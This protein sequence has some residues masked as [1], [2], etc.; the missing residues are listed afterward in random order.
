MDEET[1]QSLLGQVQKGVSDFKEWHNQSR[2]LQNEKTEE[3]R[4]VRKPS[5]SLRTIFLPYP[6]PGGKISSF[7]DSKTTKQARAQIEAEAEVEKQKIKIV[8]ES[9]ERIIKNQ[10]GSLDII[11]NLFQQ[12]ERM[13]ASH[14]VLVINFRRL[15]FIL[16]KCVTSLSDINTHLIHQQNELDKSKENFFAVGMDSSKLGLFGDQLSHGFWRKVDGDFEITKKGFD[17]VQQ[18]EQELGGIATETK[19]F[20]ES[21]SPIFISQLNAEA[22]QIVATIHLERNKEQALRTFLEQQFSLRNG[23]K[24]ETLLAVHISIVFPEKGVLSNKGAVLENRDTPFHYYARETTHFTFNGPVEDH[25]MGTWSNK[26]FAILVPAHLIFDKFLCL[27]PND[28][29]IFGRLELPR[30]TEILVT[31]SPEHQAKAQHYEKNAG[32][33]HVIYARQGESINDGIYRRVIERGYT[34]LHIGAYRGSWFSNTTG[35]I[36]NP[37]AEEIMRSFANYSLDNLPTVNFNDFASAYKRNTEPHFES[38]WMELENFCAE[39]V[40]V[41]SLKKGTLKTNPHGVDYEVVP[42]LIQQI[43]PYYAELRKRINHIKD[44]EQLA[45][46]LRIVRFLKVALTTLRNIQGRNHAST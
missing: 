28:A 44:K 15:H 46:Y 42:H 3:V 23:M 41:P 9:L 31:S 45:S 14:Q 43:P 35:G 16:G 36:N 12:A 39:L 24:P 38:F 40:E 2:I 13:I 7:F 25:G 11:L 26:P 17:D 19:K 5:E 29:Y 21:Y 18:L 4:K 37:N 22:Q 34:P 20:A 8:L 1:V 27:A 33:A 6:Q 32:N 30:G 10:A